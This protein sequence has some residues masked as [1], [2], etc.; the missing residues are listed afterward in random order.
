LTVIIAISMV[1]AA[2]SNHVRLT[3]TSGPVF[4]DFS[5]P[6]GTPP[7]NRYWNV[8]AIDVTG[9][10]NG[11]VAN[12]TTSRENTYVDGQGHLVLQALSTP[13]GYTTGRL[14]TLGKVDM[15]F[16]R[17]EARLKLPAGHALWPGFFLMGT[18]YPA[19]GW[20]QAGE[21]DIAEQLND[22][23]NFH[24]TLHAPRSDG[25]TPSCPRCMTLGANFEIP[26]FLPFPVDLSQDFHVYWANWQFDA[27]QVGIDDLT[28][29][30]FTPAAL[31]GQ[32][33]WVF[34]AP[35]T[36][37]LLFA[38]GSTVTGPPNASTPSPAKFL[39]DWFRYTP[40]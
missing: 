28:L 16:G 6:A 2:P 1:D 5:G 8:D 21:L 25:Q 34:N 10:A 26:T 12:Y 35:M 36:A 27:I 17:V 19:V 32:A 9:F 30:T 7:D 29:A 33:A 3:A 37:Y 40:N 31:S 11:E 39:V 24:V 13:S 22:S 14:N 18:D 20:P 4:D 15:L 38:V 23:S